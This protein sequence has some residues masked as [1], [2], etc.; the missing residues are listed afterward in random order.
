MMN[1]TM[2]LH[3]LKVNNSDPFG[4]YIVSIQYVRKHIFCMFLALYPLAYKV[5]PTCFLIASERG[6]QFC[7]LVF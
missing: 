5:L 4:A 2:S 3:R 7:L 1:F 6:Y